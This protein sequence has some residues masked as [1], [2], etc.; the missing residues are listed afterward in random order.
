[1]LETRLPLGA[2]VQGSWVSLSLHSPEPQFY[3]KEVRLH[4]TFSR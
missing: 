4:G 3:E 1:M 2:A